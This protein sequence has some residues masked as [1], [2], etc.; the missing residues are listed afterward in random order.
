MMPIRVPS[1][2][3]SA[4][5]IWS[6]LIKMKRTV[7]TGNTLCC[8]RR[9]FFMPYLPNF[10]ILKILNK[11]VGIIKFGKYGIKKN[12]LEQHKVFP[13]ITVLF[14]F[15]NRDQMNEALINGDG[16]LM[17]IILRQTAFSLF[18]FSHKHFYID[19]NT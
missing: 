16:T 5:F 4:S 18:T 3:I 13:V 7:I 17:G 1:P 11:P 10:I 8:S 19:G 14:I 12:R 6:R 2:L 15:I 9:F